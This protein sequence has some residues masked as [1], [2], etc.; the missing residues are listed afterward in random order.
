MFIPFATF[1]IKFCTDR[2]IAKPKIENAAINEEVS[3]PR[4]L[5]IIIIAK[6]IISISTTAL[7]AFVMLLPIGNFAICLLN[8]L[9]MIL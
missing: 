1:D 5:A 7:T 8:S 4:A 6:K 9:L 2:D 3:I